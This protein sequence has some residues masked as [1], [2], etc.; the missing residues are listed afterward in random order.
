MKPWIALVLG[1]LIGWLIGWLFQLWMDR[2][3]RPQSVEIPREPVR[4]EGA[5]EGRLAA[6]SSPL[7]ARGSE[8]LASPA[9][10][11][12]MPAEPGIPESLHEGEHEAPPDVDW[13]KLYRQVQ[14]Q[15]PVAPPEIEPLD[16]VTPAV[17]QSAAI[18]SEL[19]QPEGADDQ[20]GEEPPAV[21]AGTL[22]DDALAALAPAPDDLIVI[23]GIGPVY[24][25]KLRDAGITTFERLAA[26]NPQELA[27]IMQAP[28]WR[29]MYFE[30][31][32]EQAALL[33]DHEDE[34]LK[35]LQARLFRR[36]KE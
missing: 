6:T 32:I 19:P 15:Q 1:V 26:S 35:E 22:S 31:W 27:G 23:E 5:P 28:A 18:G 8:E 7:T 9:A 36:K 12:A 17:G 4:A 24:A 14:E 25:A 30:E 33:R 2:R 20:D 29:K 10:E 13:D 34:K 21:T 11:P 16:A 3:K